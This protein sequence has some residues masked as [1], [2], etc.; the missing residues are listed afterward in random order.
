MKKKSALVALGLGLA[1][2]ACN[3]SADRVA[4]AKENVADARKEL[5]EAKDEYVLDM[6]KFKKETADKIAA[7]NATL[8]DLKV[9]MAQERSV[10]REKFTTNIRQLEEKNDALKRKINEYRTDNKTDWNRFK[11]EFNRDMTEL[12]KALKDLSVENVK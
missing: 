9:R 8:A 4:D 1:L 7:N 6:E 3:T 2:S 12:G 11:D 10:T 5:A